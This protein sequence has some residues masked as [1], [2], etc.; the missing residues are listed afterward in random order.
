MKGENVAYKSGGANSEAEYFPP[1]PR[2]FYES[3]WLG[4]CLVFIYTC[5]KQI[6][7]SKVLLILLH[8]KNEMM[9]RKYDN[10]IRQV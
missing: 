3:V 1:A 5:W 8:K 7:M 4:V 2:T 10:G 6:K 9:R